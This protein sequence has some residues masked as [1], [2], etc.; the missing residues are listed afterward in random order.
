MLWQL[1][2]TKEKGVKKSQ[3]SAMSKSF[4]DFYTSELDSKIIHN[5]CKLD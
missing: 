3:P 4:V 1:F 5:Q 2:F